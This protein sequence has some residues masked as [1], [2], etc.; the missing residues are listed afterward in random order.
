LFPT[1]KH[2]IPGPDLSRRRAAL[3]ALTGVVLFPFL[4]TAGRS[5]RDFSSKVIR[6]PG[7]R[8]E[9][10][11]LECCI[12]CE[13]CIRVCP[14]NVLQPASFEAGLEGVW[15][16]ILNFRMGHCQLHC[17]AC[18]VVCPTGA[19]REISVERKLGLGRYAEYGPV[20][21]G[22][23]HFDI[24]RCLPHSTDV[25]CAVCEEVCPTSPKAIYR[26]PVLRPVR[27]GR[28][29]VLDSTASTVTVGR[30]TGAGA[31]AAL[32]PDQWRSDG[33][34]AYHLIVRHA[35]GMTEQQRIIGNNDR[36]LAIDGRFARPPPADAEAVVH[37]S[38]A[39]PRI[40]PEL[41]IGCGICEK[42]CPVVGDR[43][44]VCVTADGETR[45]RYYSDRDRNRTVR[46]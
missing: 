10:A 6:P 42:Q 11:F 34:L 18:G 39:V 40:D 29:V 28:F 46:A 17:T 12:K 30:K 2:E 27:N 7:A 5:T 20:R 22:T 43:R 44:A 41:C 37:L 26:E 36:T 13:Q 16:P 32:V 14:T 25:P 4:R 3:A 8:E 21:I 24:G 33:E 1:T 31:T 19:I 38:I 45:S 9:L 15:T 35:D 23:A